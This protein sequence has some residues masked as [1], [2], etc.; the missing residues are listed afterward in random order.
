MTSKAGGKALSHI[1]FFIKDLLGRQFG[2]CR[3]LI[4][5]V[6]SS[7]RI[8]EQPTADVGSAAIAMLARRFVGFPLG[9]Y[10]QYAKRQTAFFHVCKFQKKAGNIPSITMITDDKCELEVL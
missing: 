4:I 10:I 7:G 1:A 9:Q 3:D 8:I 5:S 2:I 6:I